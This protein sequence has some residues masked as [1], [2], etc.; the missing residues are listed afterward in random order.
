MAKRNIIPIFIPHYGCP[1]DCVFC[2]QRKI[3]GMST[4]ISN[5]DIENTILE[6]LS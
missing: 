4:D 5:S 2:N 6:Y 3:T 1:N